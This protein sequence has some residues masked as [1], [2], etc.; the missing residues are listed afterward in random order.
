[1][2]KVIKKTCQTSI[3]KDYLAF[4][5]KYVSWILPLS[6]L[7]HPAPPN[8]SSRSPGGNLWHPLLDQEFARR[9]AT[10]GMGL[11]VRTYSYTDRQPIESTN[12]G[13]LSN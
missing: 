2:A 6:N 5:C 9:E 13:L 7:C 10:I 3:E 1:M 8:A 4:Y 12:I 11:E